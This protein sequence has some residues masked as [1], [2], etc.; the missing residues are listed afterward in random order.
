M[1]FL[2]NITLTHYLVV[3][4][5]L[6]CL[7]VVCVIGRRSAIGILI[8]VEILLNAA[9]LNLIAFNR[10]CDGSQYLSGQ[11]FALMVIILAACEAVVALAIIINLFKNFGTI[12]VDRADK[13]KE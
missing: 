3:A 4:A 12:N 1:E 10:Y 7:G 9:N 11:V 2:I 13:L 6:F 5:L 8:G